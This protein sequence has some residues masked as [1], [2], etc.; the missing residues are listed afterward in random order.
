MAQKLAERRQLSLEHSRQWLAHVGLAQPSAEIDG[1]AETVTA[2]REV[3][4]EGAAKLVDELRLSL[5]F[6]GTQEGAVAVE[7]VV[8][9]GPGTSIPGLV[10]HLQTGLGYPFG[11][12]RPQQLAHLDDHAAA[13]LTLSYGLALEG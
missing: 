8:A 1:D 2:A 13:R 11:V 10:D 6:Y 4:V 3:L 5:E 9:S 12:G 7:S